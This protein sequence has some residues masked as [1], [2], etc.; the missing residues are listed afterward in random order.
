MCSC[1]RRERYGYRSLIEFSSLWKS[2]SIRA[3]RVLERVSERVSVW[4]IALPPVGS[5]PPPA[6]PPPSG[7]GEVLWASDVSRLQAVEGAGVLAADLA[8]R[9]LGQMTQQLLF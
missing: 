8:R 3:G 5:P 1:Q 4:T 2:P 6:P 7:R 9:R